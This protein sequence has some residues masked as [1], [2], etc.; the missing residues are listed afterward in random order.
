MGFKPLGTTTLEPPKTKGFKPLTT[1]L[2]KESPLVTTP[3]QSGA[4]GTWTPNIEGGLRERYPDAMSVLDAISGV[5]NKPW[6]FQAEASDIA[7]Q[8]APNIPRSGY[9][10]LKDIANAAI[11]RKSSYYIP[12]G[13]VGKGMYKIASGLIQKLIPEEQ[14]NEQYVDAMAKIFKDNYGSYKNLRQYIIKDPV[15]FGGDVASAISLIGG[16][17]KLAGRMAGSPFTTQ[18][19]TDVTK[20]GLSAEPHRVALKALD[21][22]G[23]PIAKGF[24]EAGAQVHG[25]LMTG[26]GAEATKQAFAAHPDFKKALRGEIGMEEIINESQNALG[27]MRI[28]AVAEYGQ[29]FDKIKRM[30]SYVDINP[31]KEKIVQNMSDLLNIKFEKIRDIATG[32]IVNRVNYA[33]QPLPKHQLNNVQKIVETVSN[34]DDFTPKGIDYLKR[35]V[36]NFYIGNPGSR[37]YDKFVNSIRSSIKEQ[38]VNSVPGYSKMTKK[39]AQFLDIEEE[40]SRALSL[41]DKAMADTG[42]R[43]LL[44]TMR[45]NFEWRKGLVQKLD[46]VSH[47]ELL[48]KLAGY[49]MRSWAPKGFVGKLTG[50]AELYKVIHAFDPKF[51]AL[52]A[53]GSPRIS[54]EFL[55]MLG[56]TAQ[57]INKIPTGSAMPETAAKLALFQAG[58]TMKEQELKEES[59]QEEPLDDME[60]LKKLA[61]E[62]DKEAQEFLDERG[63]KWQ[64]RQN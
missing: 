46:E 1:S 20:L 57:Q 40:I 34:W 45:E 55:Y 50:A 33:N 5:T 56:K 22:L 19:G 7:M 44:S 3:K 58:R 24:G 23:T 17:T 25:R 47:G 18:L 4:T 9:Q 49:T 38:L 54:G 37:Q 11:P 64:Q 61:S 51:A 53:M 32:E 31:V 10:Y 42:I 16:G 52:L 43:K 62:G 15:R 36:D 30:K 35:Q 13:E 29:Q 59:V 28:E 63:I 12:G 41:N 2:L 14:G 26:A 39:Y 60:M 8:A 48:P 21:K 6:E 27:K